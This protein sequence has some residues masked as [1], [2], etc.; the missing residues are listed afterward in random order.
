MNYFILFSLFCVAS[1]HAADQA[2]EIITVTLARVMQTPREVP[3]HEGIVREKT[4]TISISETTTLAE[5]ENIIRQQ[6]EV[7]GSFYFNPGIMR[8]PALWYRQGIKNNPFLIR[9]PTKIP[10]RL[11]AE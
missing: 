10:D 1:I 9:G 3:R 11:N 4:I 8:N 6:E 7:E 2:Q 5:L